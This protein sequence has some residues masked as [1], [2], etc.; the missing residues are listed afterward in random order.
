MQPLSPRAAGAA[1]WGSGSP[2][3]CP[4]PKNLPTTDGPGWPRPRGCAEKMQ[5][6]ILAATILISETFSQLFRSTTKLFR[7]FEDFSR[8]K[9]PREQNSPK[10]WHKNLLGIL[11][12]LP[13]DLTQL[14]CVA[15]LDTK[16]PRN[17][18]L[19]ASYKASVVSVARIDTDYDPDI[20]KL[21]HRH[22]LEGGD[23]GGIGG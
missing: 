2:K 7:F 17:R 9:L 8:S 3:I 20:R 4:A 21:H 5:P 23:G 15:L 12:P 14:V 6:K 18:H 10:I 19:N 13:A 16:K 11:L 1:S 22:R